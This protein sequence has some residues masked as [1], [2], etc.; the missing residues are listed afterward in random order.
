[1]N[2]NPAVIKGIFPLTALLVLV[3]GTLSLF[4]YAGLMPLHVDEA[5]YWYN[6]TNKSFLNRFLPNH[7]Y[8]NHGLTIY[9][10]KISLWMFGN[11]GIGLR[12]P[13]ILFGIMSPWILYCFAKKV[14]GAVRTA[15]LASALLFLNPFFLHYSHELRGY[16]S[17][18]FVVVCCYLCL[19]KLM[20]KEGGGFYW[21]L[22]LG[23]F[24]ISYVSNLAALMF[25]FTFLLS[26][27]A[28]KILQEF[29]TARSKLEGF[30]N[31]SIR[32][33]LAF[34]AVAAAV[35]LYITIYVD[36]GVVGESIGVHRSQG[37]NA[38]AVP[39]I[40]LTYLGFSYLEDPG[41]ALFGYPVFIWAVN[42]CG[43]LLGWVALIRN[44]NPFGI[45]FAFLLSFT[46]LFYL[47]S[48]SH[49]PLRSSIY[50]LPFI[51]V[52]QACG[53]EYLIQRCF[54]HIKEKA[55][56][57]QAVS[58][59]LSGFLAVCFLVLTIG[60]YRN[61][62]ADSGNP[63]V[64]ARNYLESRTGPNDMIMT[65]FLESLSGFY[66][67]D[68]IREKIS[69]IY[70]N[71]KLEYIYYL[72]DQPNADEIPLSP[73]LPVS[74]PLKTIGL[75]NIE[76][77][78]AFQ[79]EGI[80]PSS[81]YIYRVKTNAILLMKMD[82]R[83]LSMV[84]YFGERN[85]MCQKKI[86][87]DG[88]RILC[89]RSVYACANRVVPLPKIQGGSMQ[90][91]IFDHLNE[92]GT[93]MISFSALNHFD[94]EA[95][96]IQKEFFKDV[97]WVNSLVDNIEN[98]DPFRKNVLLKDPTFQIK[99]PGSNNLLCMFGGNLFNGNTLIKGVSVFSINL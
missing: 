93:K 81:V 35:F 21:V 53:L 46:I 88:L 65:S 71:N 54:N 19:I 27:W 87:G 11:T 52:F 69:N 40:F 76:K 23:L 1:M 82:Y 67:G 91:L 80:R 17:Y 62:D 85:Q 68:F 42:L 33:L 47:L 13:V 45:L 20:Q 26:L 61:F 60:K 98:L 9:L 18:F 2:E 29:T 96:D 59:V 4:Y 73:A 34:S 84:E 86:D 16:P 57:Q 49:I 36:S 50:L 51:I 75:G 78:A 94:G 55:R 41:A 8:P 56:Q 66:W 14:T 32:S 22:L 48:G 95:G 30:Q 70:R 38:I 6:Y 37:V 44:R 15:I 3:G 31:I 25:F 7:Q 77:V 63:Y 92:V 5:G 90:L 99:K 24:F 64:Q 58:F 97:F 89:D 79:N 12:L 72:T 74:Q 39:D 83:I 28:V 43:F 10:A